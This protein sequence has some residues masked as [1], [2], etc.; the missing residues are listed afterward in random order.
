[1]H[2]RLYRTVNSDVTFAQQPILRNSTAHIRKP[3]SRLNIC[4][5]MQIIERTVHIHCGCHQS[6]WAV[7]SKMMWCSTYFSQKI[8]SFASYF[9]VV[10]TPSEGEGVGFISEYKFKDYSQFILYYRRVYLFLFGQN[11]NVPKLWQLFLQSSPKKR[12]GRAVNTPLYYGGPRFKC[13][14]RVGLSW[15]YT[16]W[17]RLGGEEV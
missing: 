16:P 12:R 6:Y 15:V 1:M 4:K 11:N 3:K 7:W 14:P 9:Q 5:H 13:R 10:R 8:L 17:R 2:A